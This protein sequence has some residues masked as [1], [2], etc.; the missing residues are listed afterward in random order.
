MEQRAVVR[1]LTLKWLN[2]QQIYSELESVYHEDA[3]AM[4]T[5]YKW[6]ARFRDGRTELSDDPRS[7]RPRKSDLAE[8]IFSMLEERP[9]SSCKCL[10]RH[11]RVAKATCL[12]I[13]RDELGLQKFNLRWVPHTLNPAQKRNRVTFSRALLEVLHREQGNNFEHVITGDESWFFLHYPNESIWAESR[14]EVPVRIKQTIDAE[15]CLISILWSVKGIHSLIDIPKGESYN[16]VFFCNAVVPS[17]VANI[18]SDQR[19]RSLK[20]FYVHLDNA[21]PHNSHQSNDCLQS[22][23]AQRMPQPAYS[24]DLAPSDFFLFGFLKQQLQGVH[25]ADREA[26]KSAICQIFSRIDR[27]LLISVFVDWM[28]RLKWVIENEGEYYHH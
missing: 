11:F 7:G 22:T 6:H 5:V 13:L 23:K 27:K 26:L 19:R 17:L 1:F 3:L 28:Q 25:L 14:D 21:R 16:S 4:P 9:F 10:A 20:G 2:P 8:A 18:C 15:K 24:P 12:R